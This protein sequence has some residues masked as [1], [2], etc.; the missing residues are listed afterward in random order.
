MA[1]RA[2]VVGVVITESSFSEKHDPAVG[3]NFD[4]PDKSQNAENRNES[5]DSWTSWQKTGDTNTVK[6]QGVA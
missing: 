4:N 1:A 2:S 3:L 6:T 5:G